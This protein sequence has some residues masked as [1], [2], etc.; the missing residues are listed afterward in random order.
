MSSELGE[1]HSAMAL[2]LQLHE[3]AVEYLA[4]ATCMGNHISFAEDEIIGLA[5]YT[6]KASMV[7]RCEKT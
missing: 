2:R 1:D 5:S 7:R 4:L 6:S 3:K